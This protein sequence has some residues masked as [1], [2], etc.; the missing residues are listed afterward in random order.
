MTAIQDQLR[1]D[2]VF[3]KLTDPPAEDTRYFAQLLYRSRVFLL[4]HGG[5]YANMVYL[6]QDTVVVEINFPESVPFFTDDGVM[7]PMFSH[8]AAGLGIESYW[9]AGDPGADCCRPFH[10]NID[11]VMSTLRRAGVL[12]HASASSRGNSSRA[13]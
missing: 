2:L 11:I 13:D 5:A 7:A 9:L 4:V 12:R 1:E 10:V 6:Q 3:L 8:M